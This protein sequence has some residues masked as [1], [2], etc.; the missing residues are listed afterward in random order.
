MKSYEIGST[1]WEREVIQNTLMAAYHE[2]R[3]SRR[4]RIFFRLIFLTLILGLF[5]SVWPKNKTPVAVNQPH[6][7]L[8]DLKGGI[9]EGEPADADSL[10]EALRNAFSA[11]ESKAI[12]IRVNSPGGSPVQGAYIHDEIIRLK[13]LYPQKK[14]YAVITDVGASAAYYAIAGADEIYANG[15]SLVGSIGVLLP[16]FGASD[17][18]EK[19]GI[20]QRTIT[21]GKNKSFLDPFSPPNEYHINFAKELVNGVHDQFIGAVKAG[22]KE[23]LKDDPEIFSGLAWNG[24]QALELGLIDGI[25]SPGYVAR[26]IIQLDNLVDY[27]V[28]QGVF[29][30]MVGKFNSSLTNHLSTQTMLQGLR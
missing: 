11:K 13:A 17:A 3:R 8:I 30:K 25:G 9:M 15:S 2:Q 22:R 28:P 14:V 27:T 5:I 7:A 24:Q 20:E 10:A 12:L 18:I 29:E 23:R 26:E 19:I 21:A 4:W 16:L 6:T 1:G